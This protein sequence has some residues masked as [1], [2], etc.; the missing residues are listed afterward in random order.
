MK[1]FRYISIVL[2]A[3]IAL[4]SC[5]DNMRELNTNSDLVDDTQVK[6]MFTGATLNFDFSGRSTPNYYNSL[7][8]VMQYH[9][10]YTLKSDPYRDPALDGAVYPSFLDGVCY[11]E[12]FTQDKGNRLQSIITYI[13]TQ[14]SED[15]QAKYADIR[16]ICEGMIAFL[17]WRVLENYGATV[18]SEAFKAISENITQPKYE[19]IEDIWSLIDATFKKTISQLSSPAVS[20]VVTLGS[21]DFFASWKSSPVEGGGVALTQIS[22]N[23]QCRK[24]W[25]RFFNMQRLEIAWKLQNVQSSNFE[26]VYNECK[27]VGDGYMKNID[28]GFYFHYA[29]DYLCEDDMQEPESYHA[30][31]EPFINF[32]CAN[33][34][35]RLP[36]LARPNGAT[37]ETSITFNMMRKY[38]PDSL[39]KYPFLDGE[40]PYIGMSPNPA[41]QGLLLN[42]EN[43]SDPNQF[44][45]NYVITFN[46]LKN[47][48]GTAQFKFK[49][50][51]GQEYEYC[52]EGK[53]TF[54]ASI[55]LASQTQYRYWV[56]CGARHNADHAYGG[57]GI[58]GLGSATYYTKYHGDGDTEDEGGRT[59][60]AV[61]GRVFTYAKQC[62]LLAEIGK[63][64]A[65]KSASDW[66]KEG[67]K[68]AF[69]E[70]LGEAQRTRIQAFTGG[71][72][73]S[74]TSKKYPESLIQSLSPIR[75]TLYT[76]PYSY[77]ES[78][79]DEYIARHPFSRENLGD[80]VWVY[81]FLDPY[82]SWTW[83]R[84]T[85]YPQFK[86]HA[87]PEA[88]AAE[89]HAY[90]E[91]PYVK[92][93][94]K[95]LMPRRGCLPDRNALNPNY[96]EAKTHLLSLP[97]FGDWEETE[98]GVWWDAGSV[99]L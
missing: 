9:V 2:V 49:D 64:F 32:L 3:L 27:S 82:T 66:Y 8:K 31:S 76:F 42:K 5:K 36:L 98:N 13:D 12:L 50:K 48:N 70:L 10:Y 56:M 67:V 63:E 69:Q 60:L 92:D 84:K 88:A 52:E 16:A 26:T 80:Q 62:F 47:P 45:N 6:Y 75:K 39:D 94:G 19:F 21:S 28:E 30:V 35:P 54:D 33:A 71:D 79:I 57:N 29:H 17:Q 37:E 15:D 85:G 68:A 72:E 38:F 91:Q 95:K 86:E 90:L 11:G 55:L 61:R 99:N 18:Y 53:A 24:A 81:G 34:D 93:G 43:S 77:S 22:D 97:G 78:D 7:H 96:S 59:G 46:G 87:T 74:S 41:K 83:W 51:N 58:A 4:V 1:S 25:L 40:H 20:G 44:I 23:N 14:V 73:F 65:G 89:D